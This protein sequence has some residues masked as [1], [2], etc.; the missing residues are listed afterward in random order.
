MRA[1]FLAFALSGCSLLVPGSGGYIESRT[2]AGPDA[3]PP[4]LPDGGSCPGMLTLCNGACYDLTSDEA[5][6]GRCEVACGTGE[7]CRASV[8]VDP[9]VEVAAAPLHTCARLQSGALRCWGRNNEGQLGDNS[10]ID[11][12]VPVVVKGLSDAI[13]VSTAGFT[14]GGW[15]GTSCAV[16][17]NGEAWCWGRGALTPAAVGS[18]PPLRDI[19]IS[20][21]GR[22][23][24]SATN[25]LL[26]W[27]AGGT[28]MELTPLGLSGA[29]AMGVEVA[30]LHSCAI[31]TNRNLY[32]WGTNSSGQLGI[33][34]TDTQAQ[35]TLLSGLSGITD[36]SLTGE[37]SCALNMSGVVSCWGRAKWLG[38]GRMDDAVLSTPQA[39]PSLSQVT[40]IAGSAFGFT[41]CA[42]HGA[43][44]LVSCWGGDLEAY[45]ASGTVDPAQTAP[46]PV[47]VAGLADVR[48]I[49]VGLG[50]ACAVDAMNRV[51]CWGT[52]D[53][54][55]LGNNTTSASATPVRVTGL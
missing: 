28:P 39:V 55:Q 34:T 23:A 32:C 22:C 17:R 26:C 20:H 45:G 9:V 44:R 41:T 15:Y 5:H 21:G 42:V 38:I 47:Q 48:S 1:F 13:Q 19:S 29:W 51:F 25:R 24:V 35:P 31:G 27:D 43:Q 33:G 40:G 3:G 18:L 37:S 49:S 6:C 7:E 2:D 46:E 12:P 11:S 10:V 8:C 53:S 52:N 4:P 30:P 16:R 14:I 36:V 50:H 54:G